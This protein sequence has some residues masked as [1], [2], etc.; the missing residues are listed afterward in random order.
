MSTAS[1]RPVKP[2]VARLAVAV[3][4]LVAGEALRRTSG[5]DERM[6]TALESMATSSPGVAAT[7]FSEMEGTLGLISRVPVVGPAMLRDV[8]YRQ[9]EASYWSGNYAPLTAR[10]AAAAEDDD[11]AMKFVRI[12]AMFRELQSR[13]PNPNTA[14]ALDDLLQRYLTVLQDDPNHVDAAYNYELISRIRDAAARGRF[15]ALQQ[16]ESASAQ[17]DEGGPPP[18]TTPSQFNVI[19]PLDPDERR[20]QLDAG[21]GKGPARKG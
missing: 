7:E 2:M 3:L 10:E 9:A 13:R 4:L 21:L 14:R 5:A 20:D 18:D 12:N 6:A 15:N 8:Q 19:V 1:G 16:E 11:P 17:G